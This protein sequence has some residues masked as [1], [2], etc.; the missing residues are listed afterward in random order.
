MKINKS[1]IMSCIAAGGV[2]I[3]SVFIACETPKAIQLLEEEEKKKGEPLTKKETVFTVAKVYWPAVAVGTGTIC[4]IFGI[5]VFNA[6]QQTSLIAAYTLVNKNFAK[7]R[8]SLV[9]LYGEEADKKVR[10]EVILQNC[11]Y[12]HIGCDVPDEK[13]T[14]VEEISGESIDAY[15][16]E[17]IDAE[18]HF[19]RNFTMR[20]YASL[21]ELYEFLGMP[22]T[23]YGKSVGWTTSDGI[24]WV[25]FEHRIVNNGDDGGPCVYSIWP[26]FEPSADYL[27]EWT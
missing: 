4:C 3:T 17:I 15:E 27:E 10:D 21:N 11:N 8:E 18:Y 2:I 9:N 26:I 1:L 6:K 5:H 22:Q 20:G 16:K 13:A 7:Y 19:N 25:D 12:H 23:E 14:W 24:F